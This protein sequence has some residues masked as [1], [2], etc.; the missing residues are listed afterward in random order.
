[1][2]QSF[3]D[4]ETLNKLTFSWTSASDGSAT[5][6]TPYDVKGII[7]RISID[8]A[9]G[10]DAPTAAYDMTLTDGDG[11]EV[12][13]TSG[14]N[15]SDSAATHF[16]PEVLSATSNPMPVPVASPLT[17]AVTNAGDGN[18]GLVKVFVKK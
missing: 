16:W 3:D 2:Y 8:P 17:L 5:I 12:L 4:I 10:D 11:L 18:K 6:V 14:A 1:M 7:V 15:L 13:S 9:A